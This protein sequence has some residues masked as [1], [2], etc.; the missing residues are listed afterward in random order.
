MSVV[1]HFA[2]NL[3]RSAKDTKSIKLRRQMAAW[4]PAYQAR[5]LMESAV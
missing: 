2:L 3:A 5:V 4:T 1:R